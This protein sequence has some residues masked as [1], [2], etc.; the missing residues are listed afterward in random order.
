M[1]MA[2]AKRMRCSVETQ[3]VHTGGLAQC[4]AA[5]AEEQQHEPVSV[6][7]HTYVFVSPTNAKTALVDTTPWKVLRAVCGDD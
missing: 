4:G 1:A 5:R 6:V 7:T 2:R 3:R